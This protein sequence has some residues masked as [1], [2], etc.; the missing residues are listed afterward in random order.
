[1]F[2]ALIYVRDTVYLGS[3][4]ESGDPP[5]APNEVIVF[6]I[7]RVQCGWVGNEGRQ[8]QQEVVVVCLGDLGEKTVGCTTGNED[9]KYWLELL[10]FRYSKNILGYPNEDVNCWILLISN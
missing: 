6:I 9:N 3:A 1:M 4:D 2:I 8:I 7:T 10:S 5:A